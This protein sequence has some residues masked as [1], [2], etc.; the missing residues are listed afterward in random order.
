M[1]IVSRPR[2]RKVRVIF[3]VQLFGDKLERF[4]RSVS[5]PMKNTRSDGAFVAGTVKMTD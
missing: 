4:A 1:T 5:H 3:D 2:S